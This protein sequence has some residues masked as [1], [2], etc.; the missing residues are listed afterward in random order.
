MAAAGIVDRCTA[1]RDVSCDMLLVCNSLEAV[2]ELLTNW[3]RC[4]TRCAHVVSIALS[5]PLP[6]STG[7]ADSRTRLT[8]PA[9]RQYVGCNKRSELHQRPNAGVDLTQ[10]SGELRDFC[11]SLPVLFPRSGFGKNFHRHVKA[12]SQR[13]HLAKIEPPL[14]GQQ[15]RNH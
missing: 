12:R 6:P 15:V 2:G 1:A 4:L 3:H 8:S 13:A 10:A 11:S 14:S 5:L 7:R 9:S